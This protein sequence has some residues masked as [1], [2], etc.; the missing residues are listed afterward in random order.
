VATQPVPD[1]KQLAWVRLEALSESGGKITWSELWQNSE[2]TMV[3]SLLGGATGWAESLPFAAD[4]ST[5]PQGWPP[6]LR[7]RNGAIDELDLSLARA[8]LEIVGPDASS[9][10]KR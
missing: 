2:A 7:D 9:T 8:Y 5:L 1:S 3:G 4:L 10:S 6:P